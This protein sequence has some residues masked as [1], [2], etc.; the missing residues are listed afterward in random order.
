MLFPVAGQCVSLAEFTRRSVPRFH[1][2][3]PYDAFSSDPKSALRFLKTRGGRTKGPCQRI[4]CESRRVKRDDQWA[5]CVRKRALCLVY[6]PVLSQKTAETLPPFLL[7]SPLLARSGCL[8][9]ISWTA[10]AA[11]VGWSFK[12]LCVCMAFSDQVLGLQE[13]TRCCLSDAHGVRS[14]IRAVSWDFQPFIH[15]NTGLI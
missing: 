9:L 6:S 12:A 8:V 10:A 7:S 2:Y 11:N 3:R 15:T 5:V 4:V 13:A 1:S 14:A